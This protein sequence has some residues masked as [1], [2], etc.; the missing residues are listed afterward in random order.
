MKIKIGIIFGGMSSEHD[1]SIKSGTSIIENLDHSKYE[2]S[3]IYIDK[4]GTWY[5][6]KE[7]K[8][9]ENNRIIIDNVFS[10]LKKL[11][12]V[13]PILHG[14]YGED[15]SIQGL[16][17]LIKVPYVGCNILSSAL[18]LDKVYTKIILEHANIKQAKYVC[19][20][21][22]KDKYVYIGENSIETED[23]LENICLKVQNKITYPMFVKPSTSGSSIGI[24]KVKNIEELK[25]AIE[26]ASHFDYKIVI[27][28][29]IVGKEI[30]C[31]VLGNEKVK[32]SSLGEIVPDD[33]FYS[34]DAK[35]QNKNSKLII[36]ARLNEE[37]VEEVKKIAIQAFKAIGGKGLARIDFF[38][39]DKNIYVNE[40]NTL[41]G[42]T[43]ISMYPKLWEYD[44]LKYSDL[45]DEVI[46]LALK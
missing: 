27:E 23:T 28:E 18:A 7:M 42:F 5:E 43:N 36:P 15:G 41:P 45:L 24:S 2:I 16:L 13:F 46:Q 26:Y 1:V 17:E 20:K 31:S 37:K 21:R 12:V 11:D 9:D 32:A 10:Y 40:I 3:K 4:D 33:E 8:M 44:G 19:V 38:V 22:Y 39:T 6:L 14:K 35:Y 30:E 29:T 34:Y 25:D